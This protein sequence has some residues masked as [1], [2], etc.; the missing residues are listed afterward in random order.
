MRPFRCGRVLVRILLIGLLGWGVSRA[1]I[2]AVEGDGA[3]L[4]ITHFFDWYTPQTPE[5]Q[6]THKVDWEAYGI[7]RDEIGI[8]LNYYR[9]Q[10]ELI[11]ATGFDGIVY[12]W[13]GYDPK[14]IVLQALEENDLKIGMFYDLAIRFHPYPPMAPGATA[15]TRLAEDV[16][17]FYAGI[18]EEQRL[19]DSQGRL[20]MVFYAFPF[21]LS[22]EE[23]G[24]WDEF[25]RELATRLEGSLGSQVRIYWTGL[26][27]VQPM[28]GL[29]HYE[30][31]SPLNFNPFESQVQIDGA[32]VC[33]AFNYDDRGAVIQGRRD[34]LIQLEPA[35]L[36]EGF[37]LA[38]NSRR[39]VVFNYGWNEYFEGENIMPD[40]T[41]GDFRR[42]T[43][44]RMIDAVKASPPPDEP[45]TLILV[46]DLLPA[47]T[48]GSGDRD[49]GI[50]RE[51]RFLYLMRVFFP[52]ADVRIAGTVPFSEMNGYDRLVALNR[53]KDLGDD[54]RLR[55]LAEEKPV[56]YLNPDPDS[57]TE[58]VQLFTSQP[59]ERA[60]DAPSTP[61]EANEYA[62][63]RRGVGIDLERFPRIAFRLRNSPGS[64]YHIRFFGEDADG[65]R[66]QA[67]MEDS[68]LDDETTG[69]EWQERTEDAGALADEAAGVHIVRL[70]TIE[71]ILDD[72][73]NGLLQLDLDRLA[74]LSAD[75]GSIGWE[76]RFENLAAWSLSS[77]ASVPPEDLSWRR[78]EEDGR[79]FSRLAFL[80]DDP[81][82]VVVKVPFAEEE[83][84]PV[85]EDIQRIVPLPGLRTVGT[86][87]DE[88]TSVPAVFLRD[89]DAW[90]NY[91]GLEAD[92]LWE[93]VLREWTGEEGNPVGRY[94]LLH[95]VRMQR[96]LEGGPV[97]RITQSR[98][99]RVRPRPLP[100]V[101]SPPMPLTGFDIGGVRVHAGDPVEIRW[102]CG[103]ADADGEIVRYE[104]AAD[105]LLDGVCTGTFRPVQEIRDLD[106]WGG[107]VAVL[108]PMSAGVREVWLRA[109]DDD[110]NG[111]FLQEAVV[112][113]AVG[114]GTG[115]STLS[116]H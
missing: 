46:D 27:W 115:G 60:F 7:R 82:E 28:H 39:E 62:I 55:L 74:F 51:F 81:K 10:F 94:G 16:E 8:S 36:Q 19:R 53:R 59:R 96:Y 54:H 80:A 44:E 4:C 108:P 76:S 84:V 92:V 35:Y 87:E 21:D 78:T 45:S 9:K 65:I 50:E 112:V 106:A 32:A 77:S 17:G 31:F 100:L 86:I 18:G 11:R 56:V 79:T 109:V 116:I 2:G 104:Y 13:Y 93:A 88:T 90:I 61:E 52:S 111:G 67:W 40:L 15:A 98:W 89:D 63:L 48:D 107:A 37:W 43:I 91:Y 20:V 58:M 103:G 14:A 29:L 25:F 47:W 68:P 38:M 34:R 26:H 69:G 24:P 99:S 3:P 83:R 71:V 23:P 66:H 33:W 70:T 64:V 72:I 22:I 49:S 113:E 95:L 73:A 12:E 57:D 114:T 30:E 97:D 102:V 6:F 42:G 85:G 5:E 41:Y 75:G 110:G 1:E 101:P 105:F